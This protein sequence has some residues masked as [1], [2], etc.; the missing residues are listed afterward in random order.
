MKSFVT[1]LLGASA[2]AALVSGPAMATDL[3]VIHWW[4]SKGE[5]AAVNEFAKAFDNDGAGDHWVD[6]AIAL[7]ET[8]RAT[9]MRRVLLGDPPGAAQF[10]PGRQYEE[11]ISGGLLLQLDD[12]AEA[13]NWA[14]VIRPQQIQSACLVDGHWY[15]VPVNIHSWPWGWYSKDA[16]TKAGLDEPTSFDEFVA[17]A[18]KLQEAGI[19]PMAIGGDG[20]G[21][22]IRGAFDQ[23]LLASLGIEQRDKMYG[24]KDTDIAGG[25]D[26]LRA[27]TNFKALKQYTDEGYANRN[28]NDTTNM[29]ITGKAGLQIMGDWAR[30]EF[31]AAGMTGVED[32]G[33]IIGLNEA[34]PIVSTDG[35]VFVFF[36]QDDP[37]VE[38]AQKRLAELIISPEVQVAFNNKK[39]SM[40]V[41]GDV[42]MASAD[43]CMQKAL[44]AVED[45]AK[46]ATGVQRFI[47]EDTNNELNAL[48]T[49]YWSED[50]MSAEDAQ[51]RWVE[52]FKN[53][54]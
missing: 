32:F 31:A 17:M 49:Q 16:F 29:V 53:A 2:L 38:A 5:S 14:E 27:L 44:K 43:P 34:H 42:D 48:I 36:K 4:T 52:I 22:Q 51:A 35:D 41:R 54:S 46:I 28:W 10:N 39:G 6:S 15:C 47:T 50:S 33:C 45:P 18:P 9:I 26:M 1:R 7:G 37:E 13:G 11:L 21:W 25:A 19:I 24:D 30:G 12:I 3:E 8:A 23:I 20:N 40:P